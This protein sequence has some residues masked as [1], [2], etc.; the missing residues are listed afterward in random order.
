MSKAALILVDMPPNCAQCPLKKLTKAGL[1]ACGMPSKANNN[2]FGLCEGDYA[3]RR[4]D[5][6]QLKELPEPREVAF[7]DK[8]PWAEQRRG[9]NACLEEIQQGNLIP[10]SDDPCGTDKTM[11][12]LTD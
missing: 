1:F 3:E 7:D 9:Y 10:L 8:S 12:Q 5:W 2:Y 11:Q 4:P 6:C